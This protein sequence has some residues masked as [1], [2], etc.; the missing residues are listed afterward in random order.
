MKRALTILLLTFTGLAAQEPALDVITYNI[1][2]DTAEDKGP[3]DWPQRKGSLTGYLRQ[4]KASI[5]GLQEVRHNQLLDIDRALPDHG[6]VGVGREDGKTVG[7]YSPIFYDR[8]VW[9]LDPDEHGTFWLSDTPA[10]ANSRTW[11]N[12]HTRIC[13]WA[14]LIGIAGPDKGSAVYVYNTH[15]DHVSQ[16][17]R[18]KSGALMLRRAK[19]RTHQKDP[20]LLMGDLNSTTENPA[21]TQLL[22]SGLFTDHSK[23]QKRSSSRWKAALV[24][25][26]RIDHIFTS[27]AFQ[28]AEL[29]VEINEGV[30]NHSGS[31]HHPVRLRVS[32]RVPAE[33]E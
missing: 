12:G 4:S 14:R 10:I 3:R 18:V 1:R 30:A 25:G 5:I 32:R 33:G 29:E 22:K 19:S 20:F 27:A 7:E 21:V 8:T 6:Y 13:T 15:W 16:P 31:D 2:Q 28:G 17:S 24:A 23:T 11:G 26:L 9:K